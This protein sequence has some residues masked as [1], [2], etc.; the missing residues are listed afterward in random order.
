MSTKVGLWL[1]TFYL[2]ICSTKAQNITHEGE[3]WGGYISSIGITDKW[4]IWNDFHYVTNTFF[5]SRHGLTYYPTSKIDITA[6]YAYVITNTEFSDQLIRPENRLWGQAVAR[7]P[8]S[9]RLRLQ[10]R[11]RHDYRARKQIINDQVIDSR[12]NYHRSRIMS[13]LRYN[14]K[15]YSNGNQWHIDVM[16]E[17]LYDIGTKVNNGVDQNRLYLLNGITGNNYTFLAGYH[18][19]A[20]PTGPGQLTFRHGLTVWFIHYIDFKRKIKTDQ[21]AQYF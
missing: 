21:M 18:L 9:S 7:F 10:V 15:T 5:V 14:I 2:I 19:R 13:A 1:V 11:Y 20:I 16:D 4:S 8:L 6:G 3:V 17:F 12:I